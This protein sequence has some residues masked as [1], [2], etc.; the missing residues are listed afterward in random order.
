MAEEPSEIVES[1]SA[2][3]GAVSGVALTF[4]AGPYAGGVAG[5]VVARVVRRV[6]AE[7]ERLFHSPTEQ[8]RAIEA[9]EA[10]ADRFQE[11]GTSIRNDDFFTGDGNGNSAG[12]EFLEGV[13]RS[14]ADSWEQRKVPYIGR[15]FGTAVTDET[16]TPSEASHLVR[17]ADRLSY[18]QFVQLA[19]WG[20]AQTSRP[21]LL[22]QL[23]SVV[24]S[25]IPPHSVITNELNDLARERL[26]QRAEDAEDPGEGSPLIQEVDAFRTFGATV[27]TSQVVLTPLGKTLHYL[28]GLD[29][30]PAEELEDIPRAFFAGE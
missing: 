9:L 8:R 14:A 25:G 28:M 20:A 22:V 7:I 27:A 21:E 19:F 12:T 24:Q 17:L 29:Q 13:L 2:L 1:L 15:M 16:I 18:R 6:G 4:V 5:A 3:S 11:L 23:E 30:L 26:L 10:A